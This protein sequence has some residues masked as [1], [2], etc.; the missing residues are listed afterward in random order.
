[1]LFGP[2]NSQAHLVLCGGRMF[3]VHAL[4]AHL[5]LCSTFGVTGSTGLTV[6][7]QSQASLSGGVQ[8]GLKPSAKSGFNAVVSASSKQ[9]KLYG[10]GMTAGQIALNAGAGGAMLF[11]PGNSQAH[12]VLCG[13]RMFDV[14]A[15]KAHAGLCAT[16][17]TSGATTTLSPTSAGTTTNAHG[18]TT[19][20]TGASASAG[21]HGSVSTGAGTSA[22]TTTSAGTN[23]SANGGV[24][25][26]TA[27]AGSGN[28]N[29]GGVLGATTQSGNLPFTGLALGVPLGLALMLLVSGLAMRR[30]ARS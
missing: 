6:G 25:G 16:T 4:K 2:G 14:H 11:G 26:T 10:N 7:S 19:A 8:A 17:T 20:Q 24:L 13:G 1:M 5:G 28:S 27:T 21:T 3:D 9:T 18:S 15:L 22:G 12:L 23:A 30:A 29:A